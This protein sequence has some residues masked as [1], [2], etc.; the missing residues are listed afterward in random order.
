[1]NLWP[2]DPDTYHLYTGFDSVRISCDRC[3][4]DQ[5]L[6]HFNSLRDLMDMITDHEAEHIKGER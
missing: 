3:R 6:G 4:W 2:I 5:S 1:M